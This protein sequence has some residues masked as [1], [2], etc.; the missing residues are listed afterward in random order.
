MK[1]INLLSMV[2]CSAVAPSVALAQAPSLEQKQTLP[3]NLLKNQSYSSQEVNVSKL[4]TVVPGKEYTLEVRGKFNSG[5]GR[6][7]DV[8]ANDANGMGF[9]VS[10]DAKTLNWNN[11]LNTLSTLID[12]VIRRPELFDSQ[13]LATR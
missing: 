4:T 1:Q 12:A 8:W 13:W 2:L 6:G 11:P 7:L 3:T 10:L 5:T 9:R